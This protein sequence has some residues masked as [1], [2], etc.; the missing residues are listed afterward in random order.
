MRKSRLVLSTMAATAVLTPLVPGGVANAQATSY[1]SAT[2]RVI[3]PANQNVQVACPKGWVCLYR[4]TNYRGTLWSWRGDRNKSYIGNAANDKASSVI[5]NAAKTV[6]FYE[7]KN[8]KGRKVCV[9]RWA[10]RPRNK[11]ADLRSYSIN[12]K[13]SS[14]KLGKPCGS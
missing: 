2:V 10:L 4:N 1:E 12:D 6:R 5:N 11:I 8:Y 7:S 3:V 14:Y 13:I 9:G